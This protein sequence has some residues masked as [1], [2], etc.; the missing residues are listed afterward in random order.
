MITSQLGDVTD[1]TIGSGFK[2]PVNKYL[3][4]QLGFGPGMIGVS[5]VVLI[6]FCL[7]FFSVF[8]VSVKILNFQ[9]R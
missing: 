7:L 2:G 5:A 4:D 9:K 8:A 6:G 1:I 3:H